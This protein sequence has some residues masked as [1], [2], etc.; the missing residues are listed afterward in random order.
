VDESPVLVMAQDSARQES[1]EQ[2][3]HI[4]MIA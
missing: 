2:V 1:L 3:F 4:V